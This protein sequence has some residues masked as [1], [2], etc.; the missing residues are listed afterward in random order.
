MT[1]DPSANRE[2]A[3]GVLTFLGPRSARLLAA[4]SSQYRQ[5][6]QTE[7]PHSQLILLLY[8]ASALVRGGAR[9]A[10]R[11]LYDKARRLA[12]EH[13]PDRVWQVDADRAGWS[14]VLGEPR[15]GA[16]F[17]LALLNDPIA[18]DSWTRARCL[19][20][21]AD[22]FLA[23]GDLHRGLKCVRSAR[24]MWVTMSHRRAVGFTYAVEAE[25]LRRLG[26]LDEAQQALAAAGDEPARGFEAARHEFAARL[27][28]DR[29]DYEV[30]AAEA[31]RAMQVP[32]ALVGQ[33]GAAQH[34]VLAVQCLVAAR[35]FNDAAKV[36]TEMSRLLD[37][38]RIFTDWT[39]TDTT[40]LADEHAAWAVGIVVTG[41]GS[42]T[43]R[44]RSAREH[45]EMAVD[46]DP[47]FGWFH[48]ELAFLDLREHR[49]R[50]ALGRLAEAVE[51]T[52]DS[53]LRKAIEAVRADVEDT[54]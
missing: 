53:M 38:L 1:E 19:T 32:A 49:Q 16:E 23:A 41:H 37:N 29:G 46:L 14:E 2:V 6:T 31:Q 52:D 34:A 45:L 3:I 22:N 47:G 25:L 28:L 54:G 11:E 26:D 10:A 17:N 42:L 48:L 43:A 13:T 18:A 27:A 35:R 33:V 36:G 8:Q 44:L 7:W 5:L 30:A 51:L 40:R 24:Q 4:I 12:V 21:A 20:N 50:A 15:H 9:S 39:P